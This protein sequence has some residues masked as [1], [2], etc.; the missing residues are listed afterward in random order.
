MHHQKQM[1]KKQNHREL[2]LRYGRYSCGRY[3]VDYINTVKGHWRLK[4]FIK[5]NA[6]GEAI[7][8]VFNTV[9]EAREFIHANIRHALLSGTLLSSL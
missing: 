9:C 8:R 4:A 6:L 1:S 3:C 5:L 7:H 2:A